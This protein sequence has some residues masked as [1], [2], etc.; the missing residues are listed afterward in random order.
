MSK[1]TT[2]KPSDSLKQEERLKKATSRT[3]KGGV[4]CHYVRLLMFW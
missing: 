2:Y 3:S 1:S 4:D